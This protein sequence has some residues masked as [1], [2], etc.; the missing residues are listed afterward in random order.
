MCI[1]APIKWNE[2]LNLNA[3]YQEY[4]LEKRNDPSTDADRT[5]RM[6]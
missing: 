2:I 4:R 5:N 6:Y 1:I 3:K